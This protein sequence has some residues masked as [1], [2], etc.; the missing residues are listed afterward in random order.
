MSDQESPLENELADLDEIPVVMNDE[1]QKEQL[2]AAVQAVKHTTERL[3]WM[4]RA[5]LGTTCM[6]VSLFVV[7]L[8]LALVRPDT[9]VLLPTFAPEDGTHSPTLSPSVSPS[10][11]PTLT[12]SEDGW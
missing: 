1:A 7:V 9:F 10:S 2:E 4:T 11:T 5:F 6:C 3:R 12:P 8:C